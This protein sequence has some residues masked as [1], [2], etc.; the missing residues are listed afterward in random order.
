MKKN[1]AMKHLI[2]THKRNRY[3]ILSHAH[4]G[5]SGRVPLLY[6]QG[7]K[8]RV[9]CT[10]GTKRSFS[11]MLLRWWSYSR[12]GKLNGLVEKVRLGTTAC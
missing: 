11:V 9:I 5:Y 6:K 10:E 2:L 3:V 4:I 8:G 7:F 1:V 12:N